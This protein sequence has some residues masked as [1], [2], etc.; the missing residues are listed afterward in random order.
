MTQHIVR[1]L[2]GVGVPNHVLGY[3]YLKSALS[4]C[5][6]NPTAIHGI[7]KELYPAIAKAHATTSS[8]V[9]RAIR[10]AIS[11]AWFR[12][13]TQTLIST[14]GPILGA[15]EKP[16]TNGE[17]IASLSEVLRLGESA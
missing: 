15:R 2:Q 17:F 1:A 10:H 3:D 5:A 7:T 16:P 11:T 13:D 9:E 6:D 8:K 14:F 4:I 12:C